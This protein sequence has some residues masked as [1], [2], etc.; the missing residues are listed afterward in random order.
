MACCDHLCD[1]LCHHHLYDD[2]IWYHHG[3]VGCGS[4]VAELDLGFCCGRV[5]RRARGCHH[6]RCSTGDRG[7]HSAVQGCGCAFDLASRSYAALATRPG[8]E[9]QRFPAACSVL[10]PTSTQRRTAMVATP[11]VQHCVTGFA[12]WR[13]EHHSDACLATVTVACPATMSRFYLYHYA[14]LAMVTAACPAAMSRFYL[15]HYAC[16]AMVTAACRPVAMGR[17]YLRHYACLAT[18]AAA[19]HPAVMGRFA[20]GSCSGCACAE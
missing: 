6:M 9:Q 7:P 12:S 8:P 5:Q 2:Y 10:R 16:L 11:A 20:L 4:G 17:F 18:V 3:A 13:H 19:C 15:R 14:C 1:H